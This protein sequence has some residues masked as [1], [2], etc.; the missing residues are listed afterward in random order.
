MGA[1]EKAAA[2]TEAQPTLAAF[3]AT[4]PRPHPTRRNLWGI[5]RV[6]TLPDWQG[7]G[8]AFVLMDALGGAYRSAGKALRMYP[9]HPPFVR[10]YWRA[11]EDAI[12]GPFDPAKYNPV[13]DAKYQSLVANG[14]VWC[15]ALEL[16]DEFAALLR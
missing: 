16:F 14:I 12:N 5:S 10:A 2:G 13:M 11:I 9:A 6:V 3:A 7:L 1:P 8:L 15:D 4:L